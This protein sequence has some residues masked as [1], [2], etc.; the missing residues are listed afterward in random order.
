MNAHPLTWLYV[1]AD[2]PDRVAKALAS[3]AHAVIVDLEDAVAPDEKEAAR[4]ALAGLFSEEP[5]VRVLIRV[6]ALETWAA[7]DLEAV[8]ALPVHGVV[9]PKTQSPELPDVGD[10]LAL[11]CL[12]ETPLGVERAFEIAS[13]PRVDGISLGEADLRAHTGAGDAGLDWARSRVVNAACA[14]GLPRPYQ[15]VY[16][17]IGDAGGLARSC[18]HG[19]ELGFLGRA[20]IHPAQLPVIEQAYLPTVAEVEQARRIVAAAAGTEDGAFALDGGLVDAPVVA[21]AEQT[22]AL[23]ERYGTRA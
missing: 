15:S 20:A 8:R 3:G 13:H 7:A 10:R 21:T 6:N 9:L 4:S 19:R 12:I 2:R 11:H 5:P 18:A 22:V 17:Q 16:M 14:A 23:G 1:P